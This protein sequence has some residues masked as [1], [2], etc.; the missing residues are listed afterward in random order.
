MRGEVGSER[1][2]NM[3]TEGTA[4]VELRAGNGTAAGA[5]AGTAGMSEGE[6]EAAV[7]GVTSAKVNAAAMNSVTTATH[8]HTHAVD[9]HFFPLLLGRS[10]E[11][12]VPSAAAAT[13]AGPAPVAA[14]GTN[15]AGCR[16]SEQA[17][18]APGLSQ[19]S[20]AQ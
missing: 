6:V 12:W 13:D 16:S 15:S 7:E 2:A 14:S 4:A 18:G 20:F 19:P 3:P 10:G 9:P 1:S 5:G 8:A 17:G 11:R